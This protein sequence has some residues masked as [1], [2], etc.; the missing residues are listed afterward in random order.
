MPTRHRTRDSSGLA[1]CQ[2][3]GLAQTTAAPATAP[4]GP[5]DPWSRRSAP[6]AARPRLRQGNTCARHS[7]RRPPRSR[8]WHRGAAG[9]CCLATGYNPPDPRGGGFSGACSCIEMCRA[10]CIVP[11]ASVP[12]QFHA[13]PLLCGCLVD[14][15]QPGWDKVCW[16]LAATT[17]LPMPS[18]WAWQWQQGEASEVPLLEE[19]RGGN[20]LPNTVKCWLLSVSGSC[21]SVGGHWRA[22]SGHPS[23]LTVSFLPGRPTSSSWTPED[24]L[25]CTWPPH[26]ATSSVPGCC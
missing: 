1:G 9:S 19:V 10:P 2:A 25:P 26:W 14:A 21:T 22:R 11:G 17:T 7:P 20:A 23:N 6:A 8:P 13:V 12:P 3:P 24:A 4:Q 15:A 5:G 18:P 16:V